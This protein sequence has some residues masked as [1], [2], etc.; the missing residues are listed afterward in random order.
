MKSRF[1]C[2]LDHAHITHL[3]RMYFLVIYEVGNVRFARARNPSTRSLARSLALIDT[4][5]TRVSATQNSGENSFRATFPRALR[6]ERGGYAFSTISTYTDK[7]HSHA[8]TCVCLSNEALRP[9][10]GYVRACARVERK[11][12]RALPHTHIYVKSCRS[13]DGLQV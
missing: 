11:H 13:L 1:N 12:A 7:W 3:A 5:S 9:P 6:D 2:I 8:S 10:R 4:P